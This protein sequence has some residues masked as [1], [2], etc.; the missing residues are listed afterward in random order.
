M[1]QYNETDANPI[2]KPNKQLY[3]L[4]KYQ[5]E[6][7]SLYSQI[8]TNINIMLGLLSNCRKITIR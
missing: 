5:P 6:Y 3:P 7:V 8:H 1:G 2:R 4:T